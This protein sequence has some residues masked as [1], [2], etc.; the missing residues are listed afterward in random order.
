M[1]LNPFDLSSLH[2]NLVRK[3]IYTFILQVKSLKLQVVKW[4]AQ[5]LKLGQQSATG[6]QIL[7]FWNPSYSE[8][9]IP[10][11]N[12]RIGTQNTATYIIDPKVNTISP[13]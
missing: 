7:L 10:P 5:D 2:N 4:L 12:D 6:T 9:S 11:S 3:S 1:C 13:K 8:A